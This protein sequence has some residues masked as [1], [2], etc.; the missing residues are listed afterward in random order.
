MALICDSP[1]GPLIV[2]GFMMQELVP[3]PTNGSSFATITNSVSCVV[4]L[5]SYFERLTS[6]V[7]KDFECHFPPPQDY[8]T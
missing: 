2:D 1:W 3:Q 5:K 7:P 6:L 8:Q 4:N